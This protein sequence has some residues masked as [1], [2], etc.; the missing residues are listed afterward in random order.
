MTTLTLWNLIVAPGTTL[1][2]AMQRMT[3]NRKGVLFVC[4]ADSRLVGVIADGDIRR[5]LLDDALMSAPIK[6]MM[7]LDPIAASDRDQAAGLATRYNTIVPIVDTAGRLVAAA[8]DAGTD[9]EFL[10]SEAPAPTPAPV[11]HGAIALIPARGGSKR[12]PRKNIA[13]VGGKPLIA[14]AIQAAH[15]ANQIARTIVSTDDAEIASVSGTYG[16][17]VPWMRPAELAGDKTPSIDVILHAARW[18]VE[19]VQP[20]P[21]Y[22]VLLE[23][24]AP[25]RT[26]AQIDEAVIALVQSDADSVVSVSEVPHLFNPDELT[27][28]DRDDG[29]LRPYIADRTMNNRRLRG[30]QTPVY[31]QNGLVYALRIESLLRTGTLYGDKS[32]PVVNGWEYF[33]D[34]D[35]EDDLR[36]ANT[37]LRT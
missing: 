10:E 5:A 12:V 13:L 6:D 11:T 26:A 30:Q 16:A 25:L 29:G 17:E 18:L 4:D 8:I 15:G 37:R 31:L 36:L 22:L 21:R 2:Q 14:W 35:T 3:D 28:I 19:T 9:V 23:P 33:L 1:K 7:N 27:V 34:I 24:T 20:T 32:V